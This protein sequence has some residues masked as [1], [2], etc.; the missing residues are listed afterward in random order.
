MAHRGYHQHFTNGCWATRILK[1]HKKWCFSCCRVIRSTPG[2]CHPLWPGLRP[3]CTC[4]HKVSTIA[5][6]P[7]SVNTTQM[8]SPPLRHG[9][10]LQN[11]AATYTF[12]HSC[13][14]QTTCPK[15]QK[16]P[17]L[18]E[19]LVSHTHSEAMTLGTRSLSPKKSIV[20]CFVSS[21]G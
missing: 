14:I 19:E 20:W 8:K 4:W 3:C 2:A 16:V 10:I 11:W 13:H 21:T 15:L 6:W 1:L 17:L 12:R 18:R 9:L 5:S 7:G